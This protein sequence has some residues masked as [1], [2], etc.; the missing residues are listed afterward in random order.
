MDIPIGLVGKII[1][2]D[3]KG[4]FVKVEDDSENTGGFLILLSGDITFRSGHDNWVENERALERYFVEA[5][6]TVN[7]LGNT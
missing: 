3:E 5:G 6:W 4:H 1:A 7:W 2:G